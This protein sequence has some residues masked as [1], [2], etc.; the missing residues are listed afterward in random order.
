MAARST[1]DEVLPFFFVGSKWHVSPPV[2][3]RLNI[4]FIIIFSFLFL[5]F[6]LFCFCFCFV[7]F[8]L[9][10][11]VLFCFV[12]FCFVLFFCFVFFLTWA[13]LRRWVLN[14][15]KKEADVP[16]GI[17][18]DNFLACPISGLGGTCFF[19]ET[20]PLLSDPFVL[21]NNNYYR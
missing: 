9:F 13:S 15:Y 18:P 20:L 1:P 19:E 21:K 7:C 6:I 3:K 17:E 8:V 5:C 16:K 2:L 4:K 14:L 10:C 11:F 12:L